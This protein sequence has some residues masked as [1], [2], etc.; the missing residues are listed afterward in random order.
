VV[1]RDDAGRQKQRSEAMSGKG[2][3]FIKGA[4]IAALAT[5]ALGD[6]QSAAAQ[7]SGA[8]PPSLVTPDRVQTSI[9]TLEFKD[10]VPTVATAEKIRDTLDFTRALNVYNN[11][12][13]GA[14]AYAIGKGFQSIGAEDNTIVIFQE[15]MAVP[16]HLMLRAT[17]K[18]SVARRTG[19]NP[20]Q[21]CPAGCL[22]RRCRRFVKRES[23]TVPAKS[24]HTPDDRPYFVTRYSASPP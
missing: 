5:A 7:T 8:I 4:L 16:A 10:G 15:L 22:L 17:I 13:R 20:E 1:C 11:S 23:N 21:C 18:R 12:F 3:R 14:S 24:S 2:R 9:G 6:G 19:C